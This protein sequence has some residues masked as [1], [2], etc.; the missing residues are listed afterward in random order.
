MKE[1]REIQSKRR[2]LLA[3]LIGTGVFILVFLI[4]YSIS[5]F[6]FQRISTFQ[7]ETAYNI[8]ENKLN[9][10]LFNQGICSQETFEQ[11]SGALG[12]QGRI[13][14]DLE[15][16]LGK[17]NEK[18]LL[19]KKF[20]TLVELE[21]L[22]FVKLI[23]KECNSNINTILFFYSN[24]PKD[25]KNSEELGKLLSSVYARNTNDLIIY[26]FDINLDSRL[27]KNLKELYNI[28]EPCTLVINDNQKLVAP[29]SI[30]QIE[31]YLN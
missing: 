27:I 3:F 2:Y 11:V 30:S 22:E 7:T 14:D 28:T 29:E 21:H 24:A 18:V 9:Y 13:I 5:Y 16:K 26:S 19:R 8:F 4:S 25:L 15:K 6:E 1:K 17:T 31:T 23:N 10:A 20:Y 12:F